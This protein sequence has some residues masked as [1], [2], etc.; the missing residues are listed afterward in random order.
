[1]LHPVVDLAVGTTLLRAFPALIVT[2]SLKTGKTEEHTTLGQAMLRANGKL[3][4]VQAHDMW[5]HS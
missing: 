1:M 4:P 3:V 2:L 5:V